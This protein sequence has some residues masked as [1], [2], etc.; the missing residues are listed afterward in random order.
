MKITT[1]IASVSLALMVALAF[2]PMTGHAAAKNDGA[3]VSKSGLSDSI[4]D[5]SVN[6]G[7]K[8]IKVQEVFL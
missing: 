1:K 7:V 5:L 8:A 2:V 6:A 3:S 4:N